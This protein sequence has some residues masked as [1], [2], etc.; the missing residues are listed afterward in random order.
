MCNGFVVLGRR[1]KVRRQFR[2]LQRGDRKRQNAIVHNA[3][4][5][6]RRLFGV[7]RGR[8]MFALWLRKNDFC[9]GAAGGAIAMGGDAKP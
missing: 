7:C 8:R 6:A 4:R 9:L 2:W 3:M 5:S 1:R